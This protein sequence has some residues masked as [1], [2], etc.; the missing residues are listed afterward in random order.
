M[1]DSI[2]MLAA[3]ILLLDAVLG[4]PEWLYRLIGHPVGVF[5]YI[6]GWFERHFNVRRYSE[7]WRRVFGVMTVL[8]LVLIT[9]WRSRAGPR[10]ACDDRRARYG[11]FG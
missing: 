3:G 5:A 10:E 6:I 4:W 8:V 7:A 11:C 2:F 1:S 9:E